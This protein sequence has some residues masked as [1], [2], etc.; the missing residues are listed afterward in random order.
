MIDAQTVQPSIFSREGG[1]QVLR[2]PYY[3][4]SAGGSG[5]SHFLRQ[6][7]LKETPSEHNGEIVC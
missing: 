1:T 6:Q 3:Q 7:S 5:C 2:G 4:Y